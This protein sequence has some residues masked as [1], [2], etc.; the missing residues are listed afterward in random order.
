MGVHL[1]RLNCT[2]HEVGSKDVQGL[3]EAVKYSFV[4]DLFELKVGSF[5]N[6]GLLTA[7]VIDLL[8]ELLKEVIRNDRFQAIDNSVLILLGTLIISVSLQILESL[9][10]VEAIGHVD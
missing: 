6:G 3:V 1:H 7:H 5:D 2:Y 10:D 8:V 4:M 9:V